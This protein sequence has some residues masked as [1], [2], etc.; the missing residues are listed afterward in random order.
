MATTHTKSWWSWPAV[1]GLA[2]AT[3]VATAGPS[4]G[5]ATPPGGAT[6]LCPVPDK[7]MCLSVSPLKGA[8][9]DSACGK[10]HKAVC[11]PFI[12]KGLESDKAFAS[13]PSAKMLRPGET[14]MPEH[15][16]EGKRRA[17]KPRTIVATKGTHL[18]ARTGMTSPPPATPPKV[19]DVKNQYRV[20]A[21]FFNGDKVESCAEYA[22]K[23]YW[24]WT[25]F[26]DATAACKGDRNCIIDVAMLPAAPG[27]AERTLVRK[28]GTKLPPELQIA[29]DENV[30]L[31][32]NLFYSLPTKFLDFAPSL[33]PKRKAEIAAAMGA[34]KQYY[35]LCKFGTSCRATVKVGSKWGFHKSLRNANKDL[36]DAEF[37]EYDRRKDK[38]AHLVGQYFALIAELSKPPA[39]GKKKL[40]KGW[41]SPLEQFQHP[42]DRLQAL[43][44]QF[45]AAAA[46]AKAMQLDEVPSP[47]APSSRGQQGAVD[48]ERLRRDPAADDQGASD[49]VVSLLAAPQAGAAGT[50]QAKKVCPPIGKV[51]KPNAGTLMA[52]QCHIG[53]ALVIE[54]ERKL[55]GHKSCLD[56]D[57]NDCD[58][59]PRMFIEEFV[60]TTPHLAAEAKDEE[61]CL[62]WTKNKLGPYKKG[63]VNKN[64]TKNIAAV[65]EY[66]AYK[67]AE[68]AAFNKDDKQ[69]KA[70]LQSYALGKGAHGLKFGADLGEAE[71]YGDKA[72][73]AAG[74][75]Y[76]LG[77]GVEPAKLQGEE[78][79][80]L[81][82]H[83]RGGF[84]VDAWLVGNDIEIVDG[85]GAAAFNGSLNKDG[86]GDPTGPFGDIGNKK[87]YAHAHLRVL[88]VDVFEEVD[89]Q[90]E[91]NATIAPED[92]INRIDLPP[93]YK[94][95]F[96]I[97]AGPVPISGA[98]WAEFFYGASFGIEGE[99][100]GACDASKINFIGRGVFTPQLGVDGRAQVGVGIAGLLS[101]GIRG[102]LNLVTVGVPVTNELVTTMKQIEDFDA[103]PSLK[104]T[105]K[106]G[107]SLATLSG[108]LSLYIEFLFFEEEFEILRW[109]GISTV[110]DLLPPVSANL[111]VGG[112]KG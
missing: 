100:N 51:G 62:A 38:L 13:A 101:V 21:W 37:Q 58:W 35:G 57:D 54:Y 71:M 80:Q 89:K 24:D 31:P 91:L 72:M 40:V 17:Y 60:A 36:T 86:K 83:A 15:V 28:D 8:Y 109:N 46:K 14:D 12:E 78:V 102:A 67:Q 39:A 97:M 49:A 94:P 4:A 81:G 61:Y 66:I 6:D 85:L 33:D 68:L 69:E 18:P 48:V 16:R 84:G 9:L 87:A 107:L 56:V 5:P 79:C 111:R 44:G 41:V 77:W 55:A 23:R 92:W 42:M 93:G 82:G 1:L 110:I 76:M 7:A 88:G 95:S 26:T 45:A 108:W 3:G 99:V 104:F 63:G 43:P 50:P 2:L 30:A 98:V 59:S 64:A 34:G 65:D 96:T 106:I 103:V 11:K 70:K 73:F 75:D 90:V 74:Y 19:D 22:Y 47:A 20:P 52:M 53:Q 112:M 29:T 25:R 105:T 32:K 10:K 27:I